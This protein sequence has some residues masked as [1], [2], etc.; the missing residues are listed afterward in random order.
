MGHREEAEVLDE[1]DPDSDYDE[2]KY[3]KESTHNLI[4]YFFKLNLCS[5]FP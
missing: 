1:A 5:N 3:M 2:E 4:F